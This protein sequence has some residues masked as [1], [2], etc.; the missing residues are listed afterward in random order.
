MFVDEDFAQFFTSAVCTEPCIFCLFAQ[1]NLIAS[2]IDFTFLCLFRLS[3]VFNTKYSLFTI[4]F[5]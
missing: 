1:P 5:A 4:P 2:N 3:S